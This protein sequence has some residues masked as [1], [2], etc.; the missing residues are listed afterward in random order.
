MGA[1]NTYP[2]VN[3]VASDVAFGYAETGSDSSQGYRMDAIQAF[4]LGSY[5]T[6]DLSTTVGLTV[7]RLADAESDRVSLI[8][9][10]VGTVGNIAVNPIGLNPVLQ[11]PGTIMLAPGQLV[12][13]QPLAPQ[14]VIQAI[15]DTAG[16][17]L[18]VYD[19]NRGGHFP[20]APPASGMM[21]WWQVDEAVSSPKRAIANKATA[22]ALTQNILP[23]GRRLFD[24]SNFV[25]IA[26]ATVTANAAA[27]PDGKVY[28]ASVAS[29]AA[30]TWS[31]NLGTFTLPAGTYTVAIDAKRNTGS[32]Q[33]FR[34]GF[35]NSGGLSAIKTATAAWQT[36]TL[37]FTLGSPSSAAMWAV[38]TDGTNNAAL[39]IDN[40]R[41][42]SGSS[43]LGADTLV[44]HL[45]PSNVN[46][47]GAGATPTV[48]GGVMDMSGGG[49][50]VTQFE[51]TV[52]SA[53]SAICIGRRLSASGGAN[54][55]TFLGDCR[56][57]T[58]FAANQ[59]GTGIT[60][61]FNGNPHPVYA[62]AGVPQDIFAPE[63]LWDGVDP[64]YQVIGWTYDG[65]TFTMWLDGQPAYSEVASGQT[66][67]IAD[68]MCGWA[69]GASFTSKH[70]IN[71]MLLY[72]RALTVAEMAS[73]S[74]YLK[75]RARSVGLTAGVNNFLC[76]EGDSITVGHV[77]TNGGYPHLFAPV[78]SPLVKGANHAIGGATLQI[79][80]A[81][82][83][84]LYGRRAINAAMIP[85]NKRG[86]KYCF[87]FMIGHNDFVLDAIYLASP[88]TF[89]ADLGTFA[90]AMKS[91]GWDRVAIGTILPSTLTGFNTWR[92]TV[93]ALITPTWAA[94]NGVDAIFD[95][96][97]NATIGPDAAASNLTYYS[98]GTHPTDAGQAILETIYAAKINA[99]W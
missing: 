50:A 20:I 31:I 82:A 7:V 84:S 94:A 86:R 51:T 87:T 25:Q 44:G 83:N 17:K 57:F 6:F 52:L 75:S 29:T 16:S 69:G 88:S 30:T 21:G 36:F 98:D 72:G 15:A 91:D 74:E 38:L 92:N 5:T 61:E 96:A 63:S 4:V 79:R 42:F 10:N 81:G 85:G 62:S 60:G 55:Q 64:S 12:S 27:G 11:N 22:T 9:Q 77:T 32:N 2:L 56:T 68:L 66:A 48:S 49:L 70:G 97:A 99:I 43:D 26:G 54:F 3:P 47:V 41:L 95:F 53:F 78:S 33:T 80:A 13:L 35:G 90:Q 71:G 59:E 24:T 39:L 18:T 28:A 14:G 40:V 23:W 76:A 45:Y 93:N 37:T 67:T 58:N 65:T 46:P 73:T 89:V 19:G 1:T 34:F 8:L